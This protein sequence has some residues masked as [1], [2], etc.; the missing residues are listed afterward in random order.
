M[1]IISCKIENFGRLHNLEIDFTSGLNVFCR[2]NGWGKS[3]LAAFIKAMLYGL[4]GS[5]KRD[6]DDNERRRYTPWQGG[7]FGG[8]MNFETSGRHYSVT[9][10]FGDS[11]AKDT[12]ELRSA[13]TNLISHD[14]S[15][16]LGEEL[17]KLNSA[18]FYRSIFIG[19]SDCPTYSTDDI[20]AGIGGLADNTGDINSFESADERLKKRIN[21]LSPKL[22]TGA[23]Y[24]LSDEI[25]DLRRRV[26]DESDLCKQAADCENKIADAEKQINEIKKRKI[27][28]EAEQSKS[29]KMQKLLAVCDEWER[30]KNTLEDSKKALEAA[31]ALFPSGIPDEDDVR[32]HI[33][34]SLEM[35]SAWSLMH[36]YRLSDDEEQNLM[37]L[38]GMFEKEVPLP[39]SIDR[40]FTMEQ[41]YRHACEQYGKLR[42][43][44]NEKQRMEKLRTAFENDDAEPEELL[45]KW[46]ERVSVGSAL[47]SK[48]SALQAIEFSVNKERLSAKRRCFILSGA[49]LVIIILALLLFVDYSDVRFLTAAIAGIALVGTGIFLAVLIYSNI[50]KKEPCNLQLLRDEISQNESFLIETDSVT[51]N[52]LIAHGMQFNE[53]DVTIQLQKICAEK[54]DLDTLEKRN[55]EAGNFMRESN[56]KA[57]GEDIGA[58]LS[59]FGIQSKNGSFSD[60]LHELK[61]AVTEYGI[62]SEKHR[63]FECARKEYGIHCGTI[64]RFLEEYG[65]SGH[66]DMYEAL[67]KLRGNFAEYRRLSSL[68]ISAEKELEAFEQ[69]HNTSEFQSV[70]VESITSPEA[71]REEI[72]MCDQSIDNLSSELN[73]MREART[74]LYRRLSAW[75]SDCIALREK[76]ER[77]EAEKL[78]YERLTKAR[79]LL[80]TAKENMA[81]RYIDPVFTAF[82]DYHQ[83]VTGISPDNYRIDADV[84][85]TV[86]DY[87][88]QREIKALSAGFSDLAGICLRLGLAD[89]M[90]RDEKPMLIMDDPFANLDDEK[91]SAS[92]NLL[93][94][95]AEKYQVIYFTCS[96]SRK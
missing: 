8:R 65:L 55:N 15:E 39:D 12:F 82:K 51:E 56:L 83:T 44:D 20:H 90:Y 3:T 32:K 66:E 1:R 88:R 91:A 73:A 50:I 79:E 53:S 69:S 96:E 18:S 67:E 85:L 92:K 31:S 58:F 80:R 48:R 95:V 76:K 5:K 93:R 22:K 4:D 42:L 38:N 28:L 13:D 54:R 11:P 41:E 24:R 62:L 43:T 25:S 72:R 36:S 94:A 27:S 19:Q 70:D 60:Q 57:L 40:Y 10:T 30:L 21:S 47:G 29:I 23:L 74:D 33:H 16:R 77:Y 68:H 75:E 14:Y 7:V 26:S 78:R 84:R 61:D 52:Y 17:F 87:G 9:R 81:A 34:L 63:Q 49:G 46:N 64:T 59:R 45:E 2:E 6:I 89:A 71:L 37:R 86:E 35:K